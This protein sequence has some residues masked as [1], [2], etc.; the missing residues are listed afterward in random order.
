LFAKKLSEFKIPF[1]LHVFEK[2]PHGMSLAN[3]QVNSKITEN[4][5]DVAL[6]SDLARRFLKRHF[7]L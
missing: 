4:D 3:S 1:E 6:W 5:C 2:G 7:K